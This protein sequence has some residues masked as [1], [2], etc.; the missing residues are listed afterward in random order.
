VKMPSYK[1]RLTFILLVI[2]VFSSALHAQTV[3]RTPSAKKQEARNVANVPDFSGPWSITGGSPSWDPSDPRGA[4]PDELP[5]TPWAVA[6]FKLARPP[7][8]VN[9]TFD[10]VNDPVQKYC[11]PPG[12]T[13][14]YN[15]PWQFAFIQ[16]P[17]VVYI[18]YEFTGLWRPIALDREHPKNPD[19]TWM[20]DSIGRYEGET[21]VVDTIGLNDK[22]WIDQVGHPHSDALHLIERFRRVDQDTLEVSVT[23]DDPK[24]YT[25]PFTGKKVFKRSSSS[26]EVTVCSLTEMQSFDDEVMKTTTVTPKK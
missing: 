6:R 8:G 17:G 1:T 15:Y 2:S 25:K 10:A 5:M 12:I 4:R 20:G 23:F 13:R 19:S 11:D 18:L 14:L 26:M 21:F 7:F 24:A 16:T 22:T 3:A 9:A